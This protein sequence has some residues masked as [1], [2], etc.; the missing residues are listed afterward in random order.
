MYVKSSFFRFCSLAILMLYVSNVY[1]DWIPFV[2]NFN[3]QH[4]GKGYSTWRIASYGQWTYFANQSGLLEFNSTGWRNFPM[5]NRSEARGVS[6]N[7]KTHRIYVGGENEFGYY[8]VQP[9]GDLK[10]NCISEQF[11]KEY[12]HLGN[13][14]EIYETNNSVYFRADY[15]ILI[16]NG[17]SKTLIKSPQKIFASVMDRGV[18]Y[19]AT[20]YGVR[21]LV[22][23]R[24]LPISHGDI[25]VGKRI[26]AMFSFG[27]GIIITT[28][29]DGLFYYDGHKVTPFRTQVDELLKSAVI[30]C[31]VERN[32]KIAIGTIHRGL[33][34]VDSNTG[35]AETFDESKGLQNNTVLSVAFD[36]RGNVWAGL[37]YG[38]DY[39]LLEDPLSYLYRAPF[40]CGIGYAALVN[41]NALYL[42]TD[43]GL[44]VTSFP[45]TFSNGFPQIDKV[46]APS[47]PAWFLYRNGDEIFCLH[48]KGV[49]TVSGS[50]VTKI[51]DI[52]GAWSCHVVPGHKDMMFIG[53]YEGV[54]IV[55]KV[56]GI[57]IDLGKVN[58][59]NES[60]RYMEALNGYTLKLYNPNL[61]YST[62]YTLDRSLLRVKAKKVI[63]EAYNSSSSEMIER[64]LNNVDVSGP[65]LNLDSK[66][67]I[68]P[69]SEGFA[70]FN[71]KKMKDANLKLDIIRMSL[72][73]VNDSNVYTSNF[74]K[75]KNSPVIKYAENSVR[76]DYR[77]PSVFLTTVVSYQYRLNGGPWSAP[78]SL[79]SKEYSNLQEGRYLFEVRATLV[80]GSTS[81]D[82]LSF[83]ILPPWYRSTVA[84]VLYLLLI[85][86]TCYLF[87]QIE[88]KRLERKKAEAVKEKTKEVN[89]MK[90]EIDKLEKDKLELGLKHKSQEIANLVLDVA[91]KNKI[92]IEIRDNILSVA[93][94]F[95]K[96][97]TKESRRQLLLINSKIDSNME[98]DEILKRF[99]KEFDVV[100]DH[101]M[102]KLKTQ[103]PDL[104]YNE[105]MMCAYLKMNLSTKEIA[106]LLNISTRGV[107]TIR[108]RLRKKLDLERS[109]NLK[110]YLSNL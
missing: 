49:F 52:I 87:Y 104:N 58:G 19:V 90:I 68:V 89:K 92:L 47:G 78:S 102:S 40:S 79:T 66:T 88:D 50:K 27:K 4:Y 8:E 77:V 44:Y 26:N 18:I 31:A 42:G 34:I 41:G 29:N 48:D 7:P 86:G 75:I 13:V 5:H 45:V 83:Q 73:G 54:N 109:D 17:K 61:K 107:E 85:I 84:Y 72:T 110:D 105:R 63:H 12:A 9:S 24:L 46:A 23:E 55:K 51:T 36:Y 101:F 20:D 30:C 67:C 21:V 1:A 3:K 16:I 106:P 81:V 53:V 57:W 37:D 39:V 28:A 2:L 15:H 98:G 11:E 25:L 60:G 76:F 108:Y 94:N 93:N 56:N 82:S 64:L 100:N 14:F 80:D 35:S 62:I 22:G 99:E 43:R 95:T 10:Y 71:A 32:G 65:I 59:I 6:I 91:R 69:N 33:I 38:I 97:D 74:C 70:L 103:H 96:T